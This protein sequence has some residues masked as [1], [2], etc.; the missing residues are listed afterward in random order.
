M[1]PIQDA[2]NEILLID[3]FEDSE[4]NDFN[5]ILYPFSRRNIFNKDGTINYLKYNLFIFDF[6]SIEEE[7][8]KILLPGKCLFE[9][10]DHL[11]FMAFWGEGFRG[12][13]SETLSSFYLNYKQTDLAEDERK[14]IL[15]YIKK[16]NKDGNADFKEF[17]SSL[18]LLIFY[19]LNKRAVNTEKIS[20]ILLEKP[21]Y[22]KISKD[23]DEFFKNEGKNFE[24]NKLMNIFFYIEHLCFSTLCET[25][26]PEY[27]K[28]INDETKEKIKKKLFNEEN[29]NYSIKDLAAALR[30]F[31]SRYLAGTRQEVEI[32]EKRV[33]YFELTRL[34]L[35]EEKF[36]KL[37][38]LE[39][40]IANQLEEFQ[41]K[42]GQ[43][44]ALY[45]IIGEED[46]NYIKEI[47][48][49]VVEQSEV[50]VNQKNEE[51]KSQEE[52]EEPKSQDELENQEESKKQEEIKNQ[53]KFKKHKSKEEEE[54][55]NY[56]E[57]IDDENKNENKNRII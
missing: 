1:V 46:K 55:E 34:D 2:T 15:K 53:E 13:K 26:Q 21:P 49:L 16:R 44:F 30:R 35:W 38:N 47:E 33:L 52:S 45:E 41:L 18:N 17:F 50:D 11:N 12:G 37:D 25:L 27:K 9:D 5:D 24:V 51:P 22:L 39:E 10:E 20:K 6:S 14:K 56:G 29:Q 4:F 19:L 31:I 3:N 23:C 36:G 48:D 28:S 42:V 7:L 54:E 43:A 8:A 32:D 57:I 40:L